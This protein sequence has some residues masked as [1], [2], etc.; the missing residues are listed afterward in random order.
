MSLF[1]CNRVTVEISDT[2][3]DLYSE[4]IVGVFSLI[5]STVIQTSRD[6]GSWQPIVCKPADFGEPGDLPKTFPG[7]DL[8]PHEGAIDWSLGLGEM[9][10][11]QEDLDVWDDT[12]SMEVTTWFVHHVHRPSRSCPRLVQ[13]LGNAVTW[14]ADLRTAWADL[15][16]PT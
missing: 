12:L 13:P 1:L 16:D 3:V 10:R 8:Q 15:L 14:I 9:F 5:Q 11:F 4:Q 7:N 2:D 6:H